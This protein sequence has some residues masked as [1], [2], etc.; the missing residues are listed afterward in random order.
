[1]SP[2][3]S[4]AN[5]LVWGMLACDDLDDDLWITCCA[6]SKWRTK[7]LWLSSRRTIVTSVFFNIVSHIFEVFSFSPSVLQ[8]PI[9]LCL[10]RGWQLKRDGALPPSQGMKWYDLRENP[11]CPRMQSL[12]STRICY[13]FSGDYPTQG[14][15]EVHPPAPGQTPSL[16]SPPRKSVHGRSTRECRGD[17][18][19][20]VLQ[21]FFKITS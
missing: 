5:G 4:P 14:L 20:K 10:A 2:V 1:M 11:P 18:L 15:S 9:M 12:V 7:G 3:W 6:S 19:G 21:G 8:L 16:P 13:I 17:V